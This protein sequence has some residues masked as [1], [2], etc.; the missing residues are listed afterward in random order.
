MK[1]IDYTLVML[2]SLVIV[3]SLS[4]LDK[5]AD[6]L[7]GLIES[8]ERYDFIG[9]INAAPGPMSDSEGNPFLPTWDRVEYFSR[10][11]L[12]LIGVD[13][14]YYDRHWERGKPS[15]LLYPQIGIN[16]RPPIVPIGGSKWLVFL[17]DM[18]DRDGAVIPERLIDFTVRLRDVLA[19]RP[20]A[21]SDR[22]LGFGY[23]ESLTVP[24][25]AMLKWP[26]DATFQLAI[27]E[28][29][30]PLSTAEFDDL[31]KI[32]EA[33]FKDQSEILSTPEILSGLLEQMNTALGSA[34]VEV[35]MRR[36]ISRVGGDRDSAK[37][38]LP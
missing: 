26:D 28:Y 34:V 8:V 2:S 21:H 36:M 7:A 30:N 19:D 15:L 3:H 6:V 12:I 4:A 20:F 17:N 22:I 9:V 32:L 16:K 38:Q 11:G 37:T 27:P 5:R 14:L 1:I 35:L 31:A 33:I 13:T 25:V 10:A 24:P 18:L 29:Y 23:E